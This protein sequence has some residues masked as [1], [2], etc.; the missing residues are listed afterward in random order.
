M[1]GTNEG[2]TKAF[3]PKKG[4]QSVVMFVGL[5]GCGKT[6]TCT[7]R[8][9]FP[10]ARTQTG[11]QQPRNTIARKPTTRPLLCTL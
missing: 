9:L 6:T 7:K 3:V 1:D 11:L 2:K 8:V 10:P 4:V 5:Q